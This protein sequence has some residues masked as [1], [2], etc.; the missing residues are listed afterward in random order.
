[1]RRTRGQASLHHFYEI[2]QQVKMLHQLQRQ[3]RVL[4]PE[5]GQMRYQFG[6]EELVLKRR[7][8]DPEALGEREG[9]GAEGGMHIV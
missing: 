7:D 4:S 1:M 3:V 5:A 2:R 6:I 9:A 8:S